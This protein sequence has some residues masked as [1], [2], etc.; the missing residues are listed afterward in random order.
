MGP[1]MGQRKP[2]L[3]TG[4]APVCHIHDWLERGC[5]FPG[6][7]GFVSLS[8]WP[9]RQDSRWSFRNFVKAVWNPGVSQLPSGL[10]GRL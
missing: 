6:S 1:T 7:S 5:A 9:L 4:H 10:E 8:P 2:L 3:Y